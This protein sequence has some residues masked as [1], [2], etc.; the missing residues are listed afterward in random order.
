MLQ[1]FMPPERPRKELLFILV[2]DFQSRK[3]IR[4]LQP[5]LG[6]LQRLHRYQPL[7][8]IPL[9]KHSRWMSSDCFNN[10][11]RHFYFRLKPAGYENFSLILGSYAYHVVSAFGTV[12][13]SW[14]DI[15]SDFQASTPL[16]ASCIIRAMDVGTETSPR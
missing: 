7:V 6:F 13:S 16:T 14:S 11:H 8:N 4:V 9:M 2:F 1:P 3:D 12:A 15:L 5:F 10:V